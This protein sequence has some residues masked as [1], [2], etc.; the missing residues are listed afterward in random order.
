MRLHVQAWWLRNKGL[1]A[2]CMPM[3]I[4]KAADVSGGNYWSPNSWAWVTYDSMQINIVQKRKK[5]NVKI[6]IN[7]LKQIK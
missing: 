6:N 2:E 7:K 3:E 1:K 5:I 4:S